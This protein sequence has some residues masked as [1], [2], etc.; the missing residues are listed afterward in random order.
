M[1]TITEDDTHGCLLLEPTSELTA[2]DFEALTERFD[3]R[4]AATG[5]VPNIVVHARAF[6]G[7]SGFAALFDHL[8]FVREHHRQIEKVALVSDARILELA[9]RI[10]GQFVWAEI[11]HFPAD[12]LAEAL[13]WVAAEPEASGEVSI[14]ED[15]PDDVL[16]LDLRGEI[17]A[18]AYAETI[19]PEVERMRRRHGRIKLV[20][21]IG[22][23]FTSAT[24]G[25][26]WNDAR[27]GVMNL[28][29]FSR[30]ALVSDIE[31]VRLATRTFAPLIPGEV[32]IFPTAQLDDA[33]AW[34][35]APEPTG[36]P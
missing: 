23:E 3:A 10:A 36:E 31:W 25:A 11:R 33:K 7:W 18:R 24:P 34:V 28:S 1:L 8:R 32:H 21:R 19:A 6:P 17:T 4:V 20:Y 16:G 22:P 5:R 29:A 35:S 9:P 27:L 2:A 12:A 15:L 14:M 13:D 30:I 26:V